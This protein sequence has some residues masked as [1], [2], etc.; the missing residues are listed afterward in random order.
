MKRQ[1]SLLASVCT[2]ALFAN[3]VLAQQATEPNKIGAA[4]EVVRRQNIWH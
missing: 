4:D 3:P 2:A 1:W